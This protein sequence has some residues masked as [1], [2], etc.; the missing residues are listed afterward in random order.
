MKQVSIKELARLANV[1]HSTVSRALRNN[2]RISQE[3]TDR[4]RKLA[5]EHQYFASASARSLITGRSRTIGCVVTSVSDP[6]I[7]E[8]IYGVERAAQQNGY[9]VILESSGAD[10]E[11]ELSTVRSLREREV[12]C[13][14]VAASR[15][16]D[17][18]ASYLSELEIPILLINNQHSGG[19]INSVSIDN[20]EAVRAAVRHLIE[21]GHRR[22]GY[23]GHCEGGTSNRERKEA[24]EDCLRAF[25]IPVVPELFVAGGSTPED[26][27]AQARLLL[28]L[29]QRPTGLICYDDLIA[30]GTMRAIA[31]TGLSVPNDISVIGFDD[32][33]FAAYTHPSLTTV[34]QPM[35]E[36][37]QR[38]AQLLLSLLTTPAEVLRRENWQI[39][40]AGELIV[41]ES[42]AAACIDDEAAK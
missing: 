24:V 38:A 37:G 36:M 14:L 27:L 31:S 20:R 2:S 22:I 17:D 28:R 5:E 34:R 29:P 11:R 39:K 26:G 6:F 32:L 15:V 4:I 7:G 9:S 10:P 3:T 8:I 21:L 25:K 1:S 30:L 13:V 41:R 16:G 19:F 18:Y 42:T 23:I 40:M 33:F 12:D 35:R